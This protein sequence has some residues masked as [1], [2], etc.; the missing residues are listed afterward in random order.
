MLTLHENARCNY[1]TTIRDKQLN[2]ETRRGKGT[3]RQAGQ[4]EESPAREVGGD[5]DVFAGGPGRRL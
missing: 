2:G 3:G 4:G 1:S 5:A